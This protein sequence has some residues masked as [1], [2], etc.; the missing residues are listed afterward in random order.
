[1]HH[2]HGGARTRGTGGHPGV[3]HGLGS[4][5]T[6]GCAGAGVAGR[7]EPRTAPAELLPAAPAADQPVTPDDPELS[8]KTAEPDLDWAP[9]QNPKSEIVPGQMRSD[10]EEIPAPFTKEDADK[11][12]MM[13]AQERSALSR[14]SI[15]A[16]TCQTYWPSPFQVCGAIRDK[17]NSLGGPA[18]F[19]TFPSSGNIVNP[20]GTGERVTF[21]NGPIYW[22]PNTGAHPVVNSFLNRWGIHGYESTTGMLGYPTTDEIVHADGVGRRQEFQRGAIYVAFQNAIGSA[23]R[24]GLIRD[25]WNTVGAETPGSLLGYPIQDPLDLPDGQGQ[26]SRFERGVIYWH[27]T[28]GA[29]PITGMFLWQ[30]ENS[31]YENGEHGYPTTDETTSPTGVRSQEFQHKKMSTL[32]LSSVSDPNPGEWGYQFH[33]NDT[34]FVGQDEIGKFSGQVDYSQAPSYYPMS[35]GMRLS[36]YVESVAAAGGATPAKCEAF[37][38]EDGNSTDYHYDKYSPET[39][40]TVD[41]PMHSTIKFNTIGAAQE[42]YGYCSFDDKWGGISFVD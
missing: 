24:N 39:I 1:M 41:Y 17:Y 38:N 36:P 8:S 9:T 16:V 23:I 6:R 21:L 5:R 27:P 42:L 15:A 29:H 19:L 32:D 37:R 14:M 35:W 20:D 18:S 25:K 11:A 10:R 33:P 40:I 28:T 12:E 30:Y 26:M 3:R 2:R 7:G 31:G 34:T 13:E 22:H 4:R